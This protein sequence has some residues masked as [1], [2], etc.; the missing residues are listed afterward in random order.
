MTVHPPHAATPAFRPRA[1]GRRVA[2]IVFV[3]TLLLACRR[4]DAPTT[5]PDAA[6]TGDAPRSPAA[7]VATAPASLQAERVREHVAFLADDAQ[8][9][10]APGTASDGAVQQYVAAAMKARGLQPAG[11]QGFLQPFEITDGV[12]LRA[13]QASTLAIGKAAIAHGLVPFSGES[14]TPVS[15]K[16][17]F[18][19]YGI[20]QGRKG[21]GDYEG[22]EKAVHGAIVVALAGAPAGDPHIGVAQA[23]AASK[24]ITARDHGAA[25]FVLWDPK[26][27]RYPNHGEAADLGV[28]AVFVGTAGTPA[29][30]AAL[31]GKA[32]KDGAIDPSVV[33]RGRR[34]AKAV[35]LQT[36][37]ERVRLQTAN[38]VGRL[39][40]SGKSDRVVV[41]GAHMDHLGFGTD[42][43]LAPGVDAIHNGADD[44]ASGVAV[45]LELCG[46]EAARDAAARPFDVICIAFGAEEM[47]LLG[48]KHYV[49][50]LPKPE[51][52]RIAAM[53]NFDMVGRLGPEGVVV[54]GAG[55][56]KQWPELVEANRGKLT[57][58]TTD[59]GY[60]PSD[61]GSFYE[62][63][64]PVLH[65]FTG[66]HEDY[67]K[68]S[69]D[70]DRLNITG[71]A[72]VG[73]FALA[74][75]DALQ[76][77]ALVPSYIEVARPAQARGGGFR[78]SLGTIPDYGANVD[79]VRLSG[80]RK[81]GAAEKAG[82]RKGDVI[83]RIGT[84]DIHNLDDYMASFGELEA[85]STVA[86]VV[87]RDGKRVELQMVP[88]SP[89]PR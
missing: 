89:Q 27:E 47:G 13:D 16:L 77:D 38:V 8:Q 73:T 19:G 15:A 36:P 63:A 5:S 14:T 44:N 21:T 2:P 30:F 33:R 62:A 46:A 53:I 69:D 66:P 32:G 25:G 79:G 22:L 82:L 84:R 83:V 67:H 40:G 17:V 12:R 24:A 10:R 23:R 59:D 68:P 76:H 37:I 54:A 45:M 87:V 3:A 41:V 42:S 35:T 48:S 72:A 51:L 18:V 29:L 50:S 43:S 31:G 20:A 70:I 86:I 49:Q 58:R 78:V 4:D 85:G 80:V 60:G 26:L 28:P 34:S 57:V 71:A 52:S 64:I 74:I 7:P 61:H 39:P 65:F 81:D 11:T 88:Q 55:T 56:A 1:A 75:L 6:S 9:G